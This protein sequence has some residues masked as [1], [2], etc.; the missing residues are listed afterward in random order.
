MEKRNTRRLA[1][2]T[3]DEVAAF[4]H[5]IWEK[6]GKPEGR[7]LQHWHEAEAQLKADYAHEIRRK[8]HRELSPAP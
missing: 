1:M 5:L 2:P 6:E 3:H 8:Q 4:A 7:H